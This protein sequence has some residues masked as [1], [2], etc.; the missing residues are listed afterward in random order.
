MITNE[1]DY[2]RGKKDAAAGRF[3]PTKASDDYCKGYCQEIDRQIERSAK[4]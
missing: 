2:M 3:P 4:L 1:L